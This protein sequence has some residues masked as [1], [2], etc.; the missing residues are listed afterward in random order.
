MKLHYIIDE[1]L[2][3]KQTK[4]EREYVEVDREAD[5]GDYFVSLDDLI[6]ITYGT[7]YRVESLTKDKIHGHKGRRFF[8]DEGRWR[9]VWSPYKYKTLE[10]TG[11]V[12]IDGKR[13]KLAD[14]R[15]EVGES[16]MYLY[17]GKSDGVV[18]KVTDVGVQC[19]D[20][21]PYR[22]ADE[23]GNVTSLYHGFYYVLE[24]AE[25]SEEESPKTTEDLVANLAAEVAKLKRRVEGLTR[26]TDTHQST[27]MQLLDHAD[28]NHKDIVKQ[29]EEFADFKHSP[30]KWAEQS[31][32][33]ELNKRV[34]ALESNV[35]A[36]GKIV[37]VYVGGRKFN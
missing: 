36:S 8:D 1:E 25:E 21:E 29:A 18:T 5:V 16:V 4:V 6:G 2:S 26:L 7:I 24:P 17:E 12:R 33:I 32:V 31:D 30:S 10:P 15:A 14:R 28:S 22:D 3:G 23:E 9:A 34:S 19:V 20:V 11:Y 35:E 13:Y 27:I 37:E